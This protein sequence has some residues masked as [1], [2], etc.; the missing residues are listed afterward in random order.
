[1]IG[2]EPLPLGKRGHRLESLVEVHQLLVDQP[3]DPRRGG[4]GGESRVERDRARGKAEVQ[5]LRGRLRAAREDEA[6][7]TA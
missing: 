6:G 4:I 2:S 1:M 7:Q 3:I 5:R